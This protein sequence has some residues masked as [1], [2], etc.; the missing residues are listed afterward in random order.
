MLC[1]NP[2]IAAAPSVLMFVGS[3]G[4]FQ[5]LSR[6][7]LCVLGYVGK[8]LKEHVPATPARVATPLV[9]DFRMALKLHNSVARPIRR[10][11]NTLISFEL[12]TLSHLW[13]AARFGS[14]PILR[15]VGQSPFKDCMSLRHV[16]PTA[17]TGDQAGQPSPGWCFMRT[18]CGRACALDSRR[19]WHRCAACRPQKGLLDSFESSTRRLCETFR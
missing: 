15:R 12:S 14:L 2:H 17:S 4:A 1:F 6:D 19:R 13:C 16:A 3:L 18:L 5:A 8:R 11:L 7:I 10:V 9:A